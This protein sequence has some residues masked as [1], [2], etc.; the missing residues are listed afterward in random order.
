M[1]TTDRKGVSEILLIAGLSI[2]ESAATYLHNNTG[3]LRAQMLYNFVV[4]VLGMSG[5]MGQ[6][7]LVAD[8]LVFMITNDAQ[9]VLPMCYL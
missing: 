2:A 6:A 1:G 8:T 4:L 3:S 9:A 7:G 5:I